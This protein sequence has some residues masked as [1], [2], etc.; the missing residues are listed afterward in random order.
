[1]R[2][3]LTHAAQQQIALTWTT[4]V[5][6]VGSGWELEVASLLGTA[7]SSRSIKEYGRFFSVGNKLLTGL[8]AAA[9]VAAVGAAG[10]YSVGEEGSMTGGGSMFEDAAVAC[11]TIEGSAVGGVPNGDGGGGKE[12][13]TSS[14]GA[15]VS[16]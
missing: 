9:R 11:A 10:T 2:C 3:C 13:S 15:S 12:S 5:D 7:D 16:S 4:A 6:D 14:T 1:M 8:L